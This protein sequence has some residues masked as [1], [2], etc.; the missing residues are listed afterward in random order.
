MEKIDW[1]QSPS[2]VTRAYLFKRL[3]P[4]TLEG[5]FLEVG[6]G[7]GGGLLLLLDK[8]GLTGVGID[9][10]YEAIRK[11]RRRLMGKLSAR[12]KIK[13]QDVWSIKKKFD[14]IVAMEV[15][16]HFKEDKKLIK[17]LYGCLNKGGLIIFSA[18]AHMKKWGQIDEYAGHY[19]RYEKENLNQRLAEAGFSEVLILS[20]GFPLLNLSSVVRNYWLKNKEDDRLLQKT[21]KERTMNSGERKLKTS[22]KFL[23]NDFFLFPFKLIQNLFLHS[24]LG[25]G[26]MVK[27]KRL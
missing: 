20:Y 10:S 16:E 4:K 1:W 6:I 27:A 18:P 23:F 24:D 22:L 5:E 11:A 3:L 8:K 19:R 15:I 21:K 17:Y 13:K 14:L 26:Y 25:V 7:E 12:V 2:S 9:C